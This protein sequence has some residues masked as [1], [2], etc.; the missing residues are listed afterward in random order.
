MIE[1][2]IASELQQAE[3]ANW[4]GQSEICMNQVKLELADRLFD[5][6]VEDTVSTLGNIQPGSV[7]EPSKS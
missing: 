3:D 5:F 2:I 6:L 7:P 4:S 1:S